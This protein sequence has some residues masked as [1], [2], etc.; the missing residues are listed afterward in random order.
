MFSAIF[1][2]ICV[3]FLSLTALKGDDVPLFEPIGMGWE[4]SVALLSGLGAKEAIISTMV[5]WREAGGFKYV[6]YL[7]IFMTAI[8]YTMA[9]LGYNL[10]KILI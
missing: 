6:I 3:K 10:A 9:F 5:F 4:Q 7:F 1:G 2:L 8:T